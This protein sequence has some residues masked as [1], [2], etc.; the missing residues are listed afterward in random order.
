MSVSAVAE[1]SELPGW[2]GAHRSNSRTVRWLLGRFEAGGELYISW[3]HYNQMDITGD[4]T[5]VSA[6][7]VYFKTKMVKTKMIFQDNGGG[8]TD[9]AFHLANAV[10]AIPG[11]PD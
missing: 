8:N 9:Q 1:S 3:V 4:V 2:C 10:C 7:R 11:Q 6:Q 5:A